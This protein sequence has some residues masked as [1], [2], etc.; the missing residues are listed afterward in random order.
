VEAA[1]EQGM[2]DTPEKGLRITYFRAYVGAATT[3]AARAT[4]K[5]LLAGTRGVPDVTLSSRERFRIVERLLALDDPDAERLLAAQAQTD[6]SDDGQRYAYAAAAARP[7]AATKAKY[8]AAW[9]EDRSLAES[10]IDEA[11]LPFNTV[12]QAALTAP[13]LERALRRLP[14]LKRERRIFFVNNWLAA[15][16]DGQTDQATVSV[17][18]RFLREAKVDPDLRRKVLEHLDG[19][20]RTVKIRAAFARA[21]PTGESRE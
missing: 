21:S 4:L 17:A 10:W 11:V 9:F 8:F 7:D 14:Q 13:Y 18:K 3:P 20:E 16:L 2:T 1:L 15:F 5:S 12:E 6:P 19:L